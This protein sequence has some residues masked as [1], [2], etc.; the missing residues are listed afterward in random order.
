M[1]GI[2]GYAGRREAEPIL[3]DGLRRLEYR[4]YDSAG[5]ATLTGPGRMHLRKRSGRIASLVAHLRERPAPGCLG[6]SH[7]RW[8]THGPATDANTDPHL[9]RDGRIALVHNGV[10][11]NYDALK[12]HLREQ[13]VAFQSDTDTEVIA[14]LV[15]YHFDGDLL[16]AVCRTLPL[17]KGT[18]GP[19]VVSPDEPDTVI[20]A[21]LGSPLVLGVGDG[22]HFLASD[23]SA[24]V[25]QTRDVVYLQDHQLCQITADDWHVYDRERTRVSASVHQIDWEAGDTDKGDFEHHMLKEIHEQ[26]R[27]LES[28]M[29]GRL[30]DAEASAHFGGLN[31]DTPQL[32]RAKRI[33]LTACGTSYHAALVGEYLIEEFAQIPVEVEYASEF[34]YRNAPIDHNTIVIAVS[35]SGET[36]DTLAAL[37]E[38]KRKGHLALAVCN[39]VGSSIAREA[40]GGIYLHAGPEVGVASTKAFTS[41]VLTLGMLALPLGRL[42]SLS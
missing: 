37:R 29:R 1:C 7:T 34:R 11:E 17:L 14:Q 2:V 19:A 32:R 42:R 35:Q 12:R 40:D 25:G 5:L 28:A 27:T 6:I 33:I 24:I 9:S 21:R 30:S 8:A 36:A 15:A 41:Q 39:V 10:I 20:G 22:E 31:V 13:G 3:V 18:Y 26:P 38:S 23:P 16:E 4:G